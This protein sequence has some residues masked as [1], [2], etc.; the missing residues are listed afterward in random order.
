V[1]HVPDGRY[2]HHVSPGA[3][4]G[5]VPDDGGGEVTPQPVG[6][7]VEDDHHDDG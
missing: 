2:H 1:P 6:D 3:N 7:D 4:A 5:N